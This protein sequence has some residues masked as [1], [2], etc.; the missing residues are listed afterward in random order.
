MSKT[1]MICGKPLPAHRWK[2]CSDSCA[3]EASRHLSRIS[4]K[5]QERKYPQWITEHTCIDCGNVFVGSI[6]S[7]RCPSCQA[8]RDR[9]NNRAHKQRAR[10]GMTR[11]IG[12]TDICETCGA[13]YIVNS[14]LQRYCPSC[15]ESSTRKNISA[16]KKVW[17]YER[18][19]STPEKREIHNAQKRRTEPV[20]HIC[21][22]CGK[23]FVV[24]KTA[25]K[26]CTPE[27][28][29]HALKEY[30][31]AYDQGRIDKKRS[32]SKSRW[33]SLTRAQKDE[34]NRKKRERYAK[35]KAEKAD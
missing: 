17:N 4:Y 6:K 3:N 31:S 26:Y 25:R 16:H 32:Q 22:I 35:R 7:K 13:E 1:C 8:D 20:T 33:A 30:Q 24:S 9:E 11:K 28:R 15:A 14:G 29:E 34:I 18:Y 21:P 12:S 27:C 5:K 2:Y 23:E 19:L 10:A